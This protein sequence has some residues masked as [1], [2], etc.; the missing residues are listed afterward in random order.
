MTDCPNAEMRDRLPDLLHERLDVSVRSTVLA[1][2]ADC[3]D[4][5][6]ELELLRGVKQVLVLQTPRIDVSYVLAALPKPSTATIPLLA[7]RRSRWVD[8]RVAAAVTL[9]AAGGGSL[10]LLNRTPTDASRTPVIGIVAT[11]P[12]ASAGAPS[13]TD[14]APVVA[15]SP[16]L[17]TGP[18]ATETVA[19]GEGRGTITGM[20]TGTATGA[21]SD[22]RLADLSEQQLK[23]LLGDIQNLKAVPVTEPDPVVIRMNAA[24][25]GVEE[26]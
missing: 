26:S 19:R 7:G 9:L 5:R 16:A 4:C 8:W 3:I 12:G 22:A 21:G 25:S 1:H 10:A 17:A 13:V 14:S 6:D 15:E 24:T 18:V 11:T 23:S 20:T 2:V